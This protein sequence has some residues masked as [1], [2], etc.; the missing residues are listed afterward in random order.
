M[1]STPIIKAL[2]KILPRGNSVSRSFMALGLILRIDNCYVSPLLFHTR[3]W[4]RRI[5]C[6]P[7]ISGFPPLIIPPIHDL[8][9]IS[10]VIPFLSS[11]PF[12]PN[13]LIPFALP[14]PSAF[15]SRIASTASYPTP[16]VPVSCPPALRLS[17]TN[18]CPPKTNHQ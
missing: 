13:L 15:D 7:N 12:N 3:Y 18:R 4:Y 9:F 1:G 8:I 11:S 10:L 6:S 17:L 16:P 5:R 2:R 14:I